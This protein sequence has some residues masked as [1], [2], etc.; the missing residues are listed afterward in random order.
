MGLPDD[1][2]ELITLRRFRD[3]Y[4]INQINGKEAIELYYA[5]APTIVRRISRDN[6]SKEILQGIY[7][8]ITDCVHAI[9]S[10]N[11]EEAFHMYA[12]MTAAL[13]NRFCPEFTTR[14]LPRECF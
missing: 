3:N 14:Q 6:D 12:T 11:F 5:V 10:G 7:E 8:V 9:K 13:I 4:L 2:E 1:C